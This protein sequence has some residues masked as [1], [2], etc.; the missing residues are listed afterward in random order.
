KSKPAIL[1]EFKLASPLPQPISSPI[2]NY[3]IIRRPRL[4]GDETLKLPERVII[5]STMM[6]AIQ[7]VLGTTYAGYLPQPTATTS[8][9]THGYV[10]IMF[11][12][13]GSVMNAAGDRLIIWLRTEPIN[14][15]DYTA[16]AA[17]DLLPLQVYRDHPSLIV[18]Y[19]NSG[20]VESYEVVRGPNP[21][22]KVR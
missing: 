21:Y 11:S 2:T 17:G 19:T 12:P 8:A 1:D 22:A 14:S 16:I 15:M 20:A 5:D 13:S 10:D 18:V 9:N 6:L 7:S 3:R 4:T